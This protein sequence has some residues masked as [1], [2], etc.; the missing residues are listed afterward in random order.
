M[1]KIGIIVPVYNGA[2]TIE[3]CIHSILDQEYVNFEFVVVDD[4]SEDET[5]KIVQKLISKEKRG[6][7]ISQTH[8]GVSAA[9]NLGMMELKSEWVT[10]LD[11]DDY[12]SPKMLKNMMTLADNKEVDIIIGNLNTDT[13]QNSFFVNNKDALLDTVIDLDYGV[14]RYGNR[15]GNC[16][17]IGGKFYK[18]ELLKKNNIKFPEDISTFEDGIFNL[19]AYESAD[20]VYVN[21]K[22]LYYY[23]QNDN[24]VSRSNSLNQIKD[25]ATTLEKIKKFINTSGSFRGTAFPYCCWNLLRGNFAAIS[26]NCN[27]NRYSKMREEYRKN[28]KLFNGKIK[29]RYLSLKSAIIFLF[30][31]IHFFSLISI[32]YRR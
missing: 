8:K 27:E 15:Y 3:K 17:C 25:N 26:V 7:V 18:R 10:F 13:I 32:I 19:Y 11:A 24:S 14:K 20:S 22:R 4:G 21:S 12:I 29:L 9:R 30:A 6:R 28:S 23:C 1:S 5:V 2:L 31:K 16:R